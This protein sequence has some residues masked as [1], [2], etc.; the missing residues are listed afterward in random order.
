M[1]MKP[2]DVC[3]A[4]RDITF[5]HPIFLIEERLSTRE[6][7]ISHPNKRFAKVTGPIHYLIGELD[8]LATDNYATNVITPVMTDV[9][10]QMLHLEQIQVI[11]AMIGGLWV[12]SSTRAF[13]RTN[14]KKISRQC[15]PR[16]ETT[17]RQAQ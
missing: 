5:Y 15:V 10:L 8:L 14:P 3:T 7:E 9:E 13:W 2:T 6:V 4:R 12:R 16:W 11:L 1:E 17:N